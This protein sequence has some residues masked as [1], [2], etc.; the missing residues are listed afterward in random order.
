MHSCLTQKQSLGGESGLQPLWRSQTLTPKTLEGAR[1]VRSPSSQGSPL[2]TVPTLSV[3]YY[4]TAGALL[5]EQVAQPLGLQ[6]RQLASF[7]GV[8]VVAE[9]CCCPWRVALFVLRAACVDA[10]SAR[11]LL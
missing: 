5:V 7:A 4:F 6:P 11:F 3:S 1:L 10:C 2:L 9:D 8:R